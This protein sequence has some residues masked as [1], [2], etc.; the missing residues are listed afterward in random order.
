MPSAQFIS[1]Y[2]DSTALGW[3]SNAH[4][5][6]LA[7]PFIKDEIR[8]VISA[9]VSCKTP[10]SNGL[11]AEFQNKYASKLAMFEEASQQLILSPTLLKSGRPANLQDFY[12]S[13][14][15]LNSRWVLGLPYGFSGLPGK[16]GVRQ[17]RWVL[18]LPYGS[19]GLPGKEGERQAAI[20]KRERRGLYCVI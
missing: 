4:C 11:P 7:Q 2:F 16:E 13:L 20:R 9:L 5:L 14:P 18:S 10:V 17:G 19:S 8:E 3:L 15:L 6:Y 1:D 12:R